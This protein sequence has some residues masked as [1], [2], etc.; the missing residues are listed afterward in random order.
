[1]VSENVES[2]FLPATYKIEEARVLN[3]SQVSDLKEVVSYES[4]Y[5]G[6]AEVGEKIEVKGKLELVLNEKTRE[7][8]YRVLIGSLEGRGEEYLK[9]I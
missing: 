7:R 9:I 1:M 2:I 6:V 8:Y 5:G 4:L 3:G